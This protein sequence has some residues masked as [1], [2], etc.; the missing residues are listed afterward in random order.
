MQNPKCRNAHEVSVPYHRAEPQVQKRARSKQANTFSACVRHA[1]F[2]RFCIYYFKN[3]IS[4]ARGSS[5]LI[6]TV[7]TFP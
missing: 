4:N 7:S 1:Y 3:F 2:V 5:S 6:W